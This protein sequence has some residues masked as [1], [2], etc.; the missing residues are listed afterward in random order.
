MILL[1]AKV[2]F[3]RLLNLLFHIVKNKRY[4]NGYNFAKLKG[5]D[6]SFVKKYIKGH[7]AIRIMK[8]KWTISFNRDSFR[9]VRETCFI[10]ASVSV[11]FCLL[12]T[13]YSC[14]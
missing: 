1:S 8:G 13:T 7:E 9:K 5:S 12:T 14:A 4:T 3:H 10:R 11:Q 2:M 6:C